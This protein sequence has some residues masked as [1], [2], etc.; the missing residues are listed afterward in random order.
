MSNYRPITLPPKSDKNKQDEPSPVT[1]RKIDDYLPIAR[2]LLT[3]AGDDPGRQTEAVVQ[4]VADMTTYNTPTKMYKYI[5]VLCR[6]FKIKKREFEIAIKEEKQQQINK[7]R[8]QED[9]EF[10]SSPLVSRVEQYLAQKYAIYFNIIAN[11]FMF[12]VHDD[13]EFAE[14]NI[15]EIYRELQKVHL[16]YSLSDLKSLMKSGFVNRRNIFTEYFELLPP[17]DGID[18]IGKLSEYIEVK[19]IVTGK[20]ERARFETQFRKMFVRII[21]CA[22]ERGWNK[23]C[24][25]LVHDVQNSG[26]STFLRWLVPPALEDYYAE[27]IGQSKDD[28]IALTENIIIN[29]D[30]LS[31]LSKYDINALKSVMSKDRIKVRLPYGDRPEILQR[32]CSFVAST[33]RLEFLNDETGSV[34]WVCFLLKKINWD[35]MKEVDINKVWAQ[36]Y[37]L[38]NNTN[39][40]Y[41]LT[42]EEINENENANKSFLIRSPE[43]ELI[44]RYL[45]PSTKEEYEKW[46]KDNA[47]YVVKERDF[48]FV[49]ASDIVTILQKKVDG[50]IKLSVVNVGK[51]MVMLGFVKEDKYMEEMQF[52]IKGYYV[53]RKSGDEGYGGNGQ[54]K[55]GGAEFKGQPEKAKVEIRTEEELP[56]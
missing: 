41:Q 47:S 26:K 2:Q 7:S 38:L 14:M 15:D 43:M 9:Q 11:K 16:K 52:N 50:N 45:E 55:N 17:W 39:F 6:E 12:K 40:E 54:S 23:Q 22:L 18:H 28:L 8:E 3:E 33:N 29:I 20:N 34:R 10:A 42:A 53:K 51:S 19:E 44:Q 27:N 49:T 46:M 35:Y 36:A 13:T 5:D 4:I 1:D 56:F 32:R 48:D 25:T 30:E 21:A 31:T 24:F 37:H